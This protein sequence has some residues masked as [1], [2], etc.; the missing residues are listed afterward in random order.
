MRPANYS[1][2]ESLDPSTNQRTYKQAILTRLSRD[3]GVWYF[4]DGFA[5]AET[6]PEMIQDD[7][8]DAMIDMTLIDLTHLSFFTYEFKVLAD[9]LSCPV[10]GRA[11]RVEPLSV[12]PQAK[13]Q[14]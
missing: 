7:F 8:V 2:L 14:A 6:T 11:I 10:Y 13:V 3:P 12:S 9:Q 1:E 4:I 5:S